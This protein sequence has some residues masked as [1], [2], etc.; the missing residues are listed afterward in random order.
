M[1]TSNRSLTAATLLSAALIAT[2]AMAQE[3]SDKNTPFSD[4]GAE[5]SPPG[6][7]EVSGNVA[8][9]SDYRFRGIS[10]SGGDFALQGGIDVTHESGFYVGTWGSTIDANAGIGEL[11]LDVYGGYSTSI[12]EGVDIDV[13]L[14]YYLYPANDTATD[15]D[16]FEPYASIGTTLG[17]VGA[18]FG[19]AYAWDGQNALGNSDNL[20]LY[21]DFEAGIPT[22]PITLTAHLGYTDGVFSVDED[23]TSWDYSVGASATV[24]GGLAVGV[25][26][27]GVEDGG[28]PNILK[29]DFTEDALV[30]SLGYEF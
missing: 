10:F 11:E 19:V 18:T 1:L 23:D 9:V 2:P 3:A 12:S 15:T 7:V 17:P 24:L 30:F 14:L 21:T 26:Y 22:T 5:T 28:V 20:Y 25:S 8:V 29:N 13:G 27:V 6:P 16:Y 4:A